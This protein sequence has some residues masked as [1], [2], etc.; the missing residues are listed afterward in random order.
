MRGTVDEIQENIMGQLMAIP[1]KDFA[2]CFV[3]WKR[4]WENCVRSQGTYFEGDFEGIIVLCTMF[5]VGSIFFNESLY[6]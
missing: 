2:E 4:C 5:L 3:Q 6:F 1:T